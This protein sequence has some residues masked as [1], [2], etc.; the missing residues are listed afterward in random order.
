MCNHLATFK[1]YNMNQL[2]LPMDYSDLIPENHVARVVNDM[3]NS[4]VTRDYFFVFI[5]AEF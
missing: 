3:V 2:I 1:Y 5:G 4:L